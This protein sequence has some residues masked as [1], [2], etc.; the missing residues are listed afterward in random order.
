MKSK[1]RFRHVYGEPIKEKYELIK[2]TTATCESNLVKG[3]SL[4]TGVSMFS[5]G[6][7]SL[8]ILKHGGQRKLE[9]DLRTIKGHSGAILDFD[10]YPF[11]ENIIATASEDST[12]KLW[13]IPTDFTEN[14]TEHLVSLDS[15]AKKVLY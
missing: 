15:H 13:Q 5:G 9:A 7:G 8:A 14:L 2:P 1:L 12:I 11:D 10:F 3:N 4:Y 6:G